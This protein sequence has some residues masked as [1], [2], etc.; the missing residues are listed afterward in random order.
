MDSLLDSQDIILA[1]LLKQKRRAKGITQ[2]Q[3][4][5]KLH[6]QQSYISKLENAKLK[7][8][9]IESIKLCKAMNITYDDFCKEIMELLKVNK[10]L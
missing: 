5:D 6:Y 10:V 7:L 2:K 1:D 8:T 3:L 9:V 4:A